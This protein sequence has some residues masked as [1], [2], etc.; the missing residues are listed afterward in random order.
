MNK[1]WNYINGAYEFYFYPYEEDNLVLT[2]V[3]DKNNENVFWYSSGMLKV[4][5]DCIEA[6][7]VESAKEEFEDMIYNELEDRV[8]YYSRLSDMFWE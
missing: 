6:R 8:A 3:Q 5:Y 7:N 1:E 2:F 4:E